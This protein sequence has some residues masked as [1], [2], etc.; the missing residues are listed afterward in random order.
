MNKTFFLF[1]SLA[2]LASFT[3]CSQRKSTSTDN[4]NQLDSI[5]IA[6]IQKKYPQPKG[7]QK[8]VISVPKKPDE[9]QFIVEIVPG[10]TMLMDECNDYSLQGEFVED[11]FADEDVLRYIYR[12]EGEVVQT[13]LG[14]ATD[15]LHTEFACGMPVLVDYNSSR[16]TVVYLPKDIELKHTVWK[17]TEMIQVEHDPENKLFEKRPFNLTKDKYDGYILQLP[18]GSENSKIE[19]VVGITKKVDC[20]RHR[21]IDVTFGDAG[22]MN[23]SPR[24]FMIFDSDG[25]IAST[26]MGCPDRELTGKFIYGETRRV[27]YT[28]DPLVI[29]IPKGFELRYRIWESVT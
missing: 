14:C 10:K 29:F 23:F 2:F 13:L 17:V 18:A 11:S 19:L 21:L 24:M 3:N 6:A 7:Y 25:E 1:I 4:A 12:S 26:R 16:L 22:D 20:N 27:P 5:E 28:T 15:S 9:S 8:Q